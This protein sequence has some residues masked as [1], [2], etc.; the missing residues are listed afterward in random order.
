MDFISYSDREMDIVKNGIQAIGAVLLGTDSEAKRRLLFCLDRFLDPYYGYELPY[1][2][3]IVVMLEKVII[4]PNALEVKEDALEL[5][6]CYAWPPFPVLEENFSCIETELQGNVRYALNMGKESE[7]LLLM[8]KE[9]ETAYRELA[10]E[11][12]GKQEL[13]GV[14]PK[15][16][17]VKYY[18]GDIDDKKTEY[19][20]GSEK[21][22]KYETGK[23]NQV[24]NHVHAVLKPIS[25]IFYPEADFRILV[26]LGKEQALLECRL[27]PSCGREYSYKLNMQGKCAG[28]VNRQIT[29]NRYVD[30]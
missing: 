15:S 16:V 18:C 19:N 10:D 8:L 9:C 17:I 13:Y 26:D 2:R 23:F 22:W 24:D 27:G 29:S 20:F 30:V 28:L 11:L 14:F 3:E 21:T 4:S 25:K 6:T 12:Y 5:L 1:E 7:I